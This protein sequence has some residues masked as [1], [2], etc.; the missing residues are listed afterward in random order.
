MDFMKWMVQ[1]VL[2]D[3]IT[4]ITV[5][6]ILFCWTLGVA[7]IVKHGWTPKEEAE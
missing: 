6:G 7:D 3:N 1:D 5:A 2:S 4:W